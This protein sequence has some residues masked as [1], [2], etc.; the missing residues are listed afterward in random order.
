MQK[1]TKSEFMHKVINDLYEKKRINRE[2]LQCA[3]TH[4]INN[5]NKTKDFLRRKR[6]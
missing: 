1:L 5:C 6:K 4:S 2:K 3:D